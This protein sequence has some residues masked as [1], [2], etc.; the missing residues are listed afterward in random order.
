M[1]DQGDASMAGA[2]VV[3]LMPNDDWISATQ[4]KSMWTSVES[5]HAGGPFEIDAFL[6]TSNSIML[7]TRKSSA[8]AGQALVNGGLVAADLGV[9]VPG[10]GGVGMQLNY[11]NRHTDVIRLRESTLG[12]LEL[13]RGP[14]I[15]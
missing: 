15:R 10:N 2:S 14:R 3:S 13:L 5:S 7:L 8:Y 6:Y 11:D 12:E 1:V 4:L 9:L